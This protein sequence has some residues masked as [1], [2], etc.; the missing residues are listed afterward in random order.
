MKKLLLAISFLTLCVFSYAKDTQLKGFV[1]IPAGANLKSFYIGQYPVTNEE[2]KKFADD[3]KAKAPKYWKNGIY[4]TGKEKHPVVFVSYEDALAYCKWLESKYPN[5]TF[6]LPTK[7]EWEYAA[8]GGKEY[9]FP[10]GD[11]TDDNKFNYNKLVAS[12]YLKQNP[13]VT[14]NNSKSAQYGKS[15][16]LNQVISINQRGGISGWIDHK[17][18]TGFVYTDL[19][20]KLMDEGGYTTPVDQYPGGKSPFD[21]WD[22]SGNVW[23]WTSSLI[24]ATNGAEKG[25]SV[26]AIKGGS[27]YANPS[28]CKISMQGEGRRPNSG[29]NTVGFRVVAFNKGEDNEDYNA[30]V[31]SD[32]TPVEKEVKGPTKPSF[33]TH[34]KPSKRPNKKP[35]LKPSGRKYK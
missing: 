27:W 4:P 3:T 33:N 10:W 9:Q 20:T 18:Y 19:F 31:K 5:Y 30:K 8:S 16:P 17:N 29:Y 12:I 21:V 34:P 6:R 26:Y 2:Y 22:M 32:N 24:T 14:Y 28:S 13:T 1:N 7:T 23:E 35:P 15:M 11:E 25:Q